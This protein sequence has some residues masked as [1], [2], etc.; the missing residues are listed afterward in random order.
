MK[1]LELTKATASLADYAKAISQEPLVLT[2]GGKPI[3]ALVSV[4]NSDL[5]SVTLSTHP[6]FLALI[7]RSRA[8]L[9]TEGG[10]SSAKMRQRLRLE[11]KTYPLASRQPSQAVKE[12]REPAKP[13][14]RKGKKSH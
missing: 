12:R 8:R 5:E 7:E 1:T 13:H 4:E 14:Q 3:A 2:K 10:V 9:K 11:K 6:Q